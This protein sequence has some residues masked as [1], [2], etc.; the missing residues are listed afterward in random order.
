[1]LS[2]IWD[3]HIITAFSNLKQWLVQTYKASQLSMSVGCRKALINLFLRDHVNFGCIKKKCKSLGL[4]K[5]S[6]FWTI[7]RFKWANAQ[8]IQKEEEE[9]A[10]WTISP[11]D[12]WTKCSLFFSIPGKANIAVDNKR[13]CDK[14]FTY[15]CLS[16]FC[17]LLLCKYLFS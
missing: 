5:K 3:R 16:G 12:V 2:F 6:C 14:L 10:D 11:C 15:L 17:R 4:D 8:L 7:S 9:V 13:C 1:M